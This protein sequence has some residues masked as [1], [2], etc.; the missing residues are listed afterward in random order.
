MSTGRKSFILNLGSEDALRYKIESLRKELSHLQDVSRKDKSLLV[1]QS[2][3]IASLKASPFNKQLTSEL[4]K[5]K[6]DLK[7]SSLLVVRLRATKELMS[8][9]LA[10]DN[11]RI[12]SLLVSLS[13]LVSKIKSQ[14]RCETERSHLY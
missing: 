9:E 1:S 8:A 14:G 13:A 6:Q 4:L 10:L 5:K 3:E 12:K 7:E 2:L 11:S